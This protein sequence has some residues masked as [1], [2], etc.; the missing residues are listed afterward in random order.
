[1]TCL[2]VI[3]THQWINDQ[4]LI[5][6]RFAKCTSSRWAVRFSWVVLTVIGRILAAYDW[7]HLRGRALHHSLVAM[8]RPNRSSLIIYSRS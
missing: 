1:M 2:N 8:R 3:T 4:R 7:C 5:I 6:E